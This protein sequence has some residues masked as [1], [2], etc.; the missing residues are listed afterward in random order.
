MSGFS[1]HEQRTATRR[2]LL[3]NV[4]CHI[5]ENNEPEVWL[6]D[7]AATGCQ[8]I[9]RA[10]LLQ[11]HQHIIIQ[12]RETGDLPGVVRW[13]FGTKAGIAFDRPIDEA[14][15][16]SL[17]N[18]LP[19]PSPPVQQSAFLDQFGRPLPDWPRAER[20]SHRAQRSG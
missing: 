1:D 3:L 20:R 2:S 6:T 4:R 9:L 10:G 18:A 11:V 17:L 19:K 12:P 16:E 13:S 14:R 15:L 7:L 5:A 8:L